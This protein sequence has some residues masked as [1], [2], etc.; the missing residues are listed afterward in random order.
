M[1]MYEGRFI[2]LQDPL[3]EE[4]VTVNGM[5]L[6]PERSLKVYS[7]SPTGFSWGYPGSGPAQL[8]LAILLDYYDDAEKALEFYQEFKLLTVCRWNQNRPWAISG[9][10]IEDAVSA[11]AKGRGD[12]ARRSELG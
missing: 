5:R 6:L 8:S 10:E 2:D 7:H 1:K 9:A 11:I 12:A 4:I 3:S